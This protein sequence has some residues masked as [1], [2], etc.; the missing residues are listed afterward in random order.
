MEKKLPEGWEWKRL[1]DAAEL[2][3]GQSPPG[4]TYN[5]IDQGMPFLQGKSEFGDI[6]PEHVKYTTKPL[7]IAPKGSV[8]MSVRAPVGDVNIAGIDYCIGRG[9]ASLSLYK[10][11]NAF[12]FYVLNYFKNKIEKE[13][14][15]STFK[16]ITKS[17]LQKFKIPL[18]PIETQR[19]IVAILAK[20]EETKKLRM[21]AD[22]L[23]SRLLQSVF[24]EMFGDPVINNKNLEIKTIEELSSEIVDC[25]HSTPKYV[26]SVTDFPCIRTTELKEGYIDWK[27]MKYLDEHEYKKRVNRLI[28]IEGDVIYGREGSFGEAARVPANTN[29]SLGQRVMLFRPKSK[30]C[31]SVFL[32]ELM[33]SNSIYFQALKKTSGSTVR[34][35]N[36]KDIKKFKGICPPIELQNKFAQVVEKIE[37][38]QQTQKQSQQEIDN[39]FNALMQKAFKGELVA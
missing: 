38:V 2:I 37:A 33:R 1:G 28:P 13:G 22:E 14:T 17:K 21:Q 6:S 31:N 15:G 36:I 34:H 9:L 19:K 7:K 11:E 32:W 16:A 5:E 18:P 39:L 10:G 12:L 3:M 24:F 4:D 30:I 26:D 35:V 8:L 20:A 23:T 29:I 25:P 27:Q